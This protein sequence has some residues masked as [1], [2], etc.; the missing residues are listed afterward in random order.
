MPSSYSDCYSFLLT[1]N[2]STKLMLTNPAGLWMIE[3]DEV[4]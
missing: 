3:D 2:M 1:A 4:K